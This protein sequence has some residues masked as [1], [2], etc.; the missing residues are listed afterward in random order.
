METRELAK[1]EW[2]A[3]LAR[4]SRQLGERS[5]MIEVDA[6]GLGSQVEAEHAPLLGLSYD[7]RS[8]VV[9]MN[10]AGI[11]HLIHSPASIHVAFDGVRL[12]SLQVVDS[13]GTHHIINPESPLAL[14]A[15]E[16]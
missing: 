2:A 5:V 10:V 7:D 4:I 12:V 14:P 6:L 1:G 9:Q 8:D 11:E 16:G 15:G 13:D 3:M